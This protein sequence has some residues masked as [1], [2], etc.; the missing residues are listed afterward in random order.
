MIL[1]NHQQTTVY[2]KA[3][4]YE[5]VLRGGVP[6]GFELKIKAAVLN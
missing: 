6:A 4:A 1:K 5:R 2:I 3:N